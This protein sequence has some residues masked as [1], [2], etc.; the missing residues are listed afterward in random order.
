M[1]SSRTSDLTPHHN[2]YIVYARYAVLRHQRALQIATEYAPPL[3]RWTLIANHDTA[4]A[5]RWSFKHSLNYVQSCQKLV[6]VASLGRTS[7]HWNAAR[8]LGL[9][10]VRISVNRVH[11][12]ALAHT[13]LSI[14]EQ[15]HNN[16]SSQIQQS[17]SQTG[18]LHHLGVAIFNKFGFWGCRTACSWH[19]GALWGRSTRGCRTRSSSCRPSKNV[20]SR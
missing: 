16:F 7:V 19:S 2:Q 8:N 11:A 14:A 15:G 5:L 17:S 13:L 12:G 4:S 3:N 6:S 18:E 9:Q 1:K 10:K 20:K